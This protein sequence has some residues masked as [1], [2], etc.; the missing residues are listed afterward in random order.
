MF[1]I[2]VSRR[3]DLKEVEN[4]ELKCMIHGL[5]VCTDIRRGRSSGILGPCATHIAKQPSRRL[6]PSFPPNC[7]KDFVNS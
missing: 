5:I 6:V 4:F 7:I 3:A 1:P 2:I